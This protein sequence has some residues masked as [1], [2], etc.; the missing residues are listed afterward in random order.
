MLFVFVCIWIF[1][2]YEDDTD[3][4]DHEWV[5]R[6]LWVVKRRLTTKLSDVS[7]LDDICLMELQILK[8]IDWNV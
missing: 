3:V 5:V 6:H 7:V 2:K 8:A 1:L 4:Y